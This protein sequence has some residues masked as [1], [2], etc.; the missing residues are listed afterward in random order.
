M[1]LHLFKNCL[2]FLLVNHLHNFYLF[3]LL[4]S[5]RSS[6][7]ALV[8]Q[9]AKSLLAMQEIWVWSLGQEDLL[10]KGKATHSSILAWRIPCVEEPEVGYNPWGPK[11]SDT[12]ECLTFSGDLYMSTRLSS[13]MWAA[14]NFS[15]LLFVC[16]RAFFSRKFFFYV[17]NVISTSFCGFRSFSQRSFPVYILSHFFLCFL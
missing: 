11:D 1:F 2:Y 15:N 14:S 13:V 9:T 6:L 4:L 8:A 12:T 17:I 5:C 10:E 3:C 7:W 16:N